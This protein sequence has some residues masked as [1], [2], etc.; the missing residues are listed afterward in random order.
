VLTRL[1]QTVEERIIETWHKAEGDEVAKGEVLLEIT[2]DKATLEVESLVTGTV[3]KILAET[4]VA[5][6]VGEVIAYVGDKDDPIPDVSDKA[7]VEAA[8]TSEKKAE[9]PVALEFSAAASV[10]AEATARTMAT[11]TGTAGA[12]Q[13]SGRVFI[14]PRAKRL[15]REEKVPLQFLSGSGPNGR[16]VEKDVTD[17]VS[18]LSG[19]TVTPTAKELAFQRGVDLTAVQ[20]SGEG[21]KIV[22]DDIAAKPAGVGL[23]APAISGVARR[24]PLSAMRRVVADRMT[25]SKTT[26]PH[27]YL[28]V[29]VDM[30]DAVAFRSMIANTIGVKF[31]Y[32]DLLAKACAVAMKK[33]PTVNAAWDGDAVAYRGEVNVGYAVSIDEGLMVPVVRQV[34]H[35][36]L[37]QI[38]EE[39]KSL[40]EKARGKRLTPDEYGNGSITISNLGMMGI[41]SFIPVINPG[42]SAIL[43][44]GRIADKVVV[45]DG[46]IHVR[47]MM[48]ITISADHRVVDGCVGAEFLGLVKNLL[49]NPGEIK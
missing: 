3:R 18:R 40:V 30:T 6:P 8:S 46:G 49:E 1:G 17:Y 21:G 29:E 4:G 43:G 20:G 34:D 35:K 9:E 23:S 13:P 15:A 10:A 5:I 24:E 36:Q 25:L 16:I 38:A 2:T 42:E 48:S 39:S 31:S 14:S 28:T 19:I 33:V 41:D 7:P 45:R 37:A 44:V 26:T 27:Y 47:K 22:K 32:N 12:P 11:A